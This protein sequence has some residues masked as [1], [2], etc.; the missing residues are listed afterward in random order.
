MNEVCFHLPD[1]RVLERATFGVVFVPSFAPRGLAA[2]ER[3]HA[4]ALEMENKVRMLETD[5]MK[6]QLVHSLL[7]NVSTQATLLMGFALATFGADLLPQ[8]MND[9]SSFCIFKSNAYMFVGFS[10]LL[11]N[12]CCVSF[13]MLVIVFSSLLITRS[14]EAYLH[15]GG[16][17]AVFRTQC[18]VSE[19]YTWAGLAGGSFLT[20]AILV[21][22]VF[23]GL[24]AFVEKAPGLDAREYADY[25]DYTTNSGRILYRC[26]DLEDEAQHIRR[27]NFGI[28]VASTNTAA[29]LL[30]IW[31]GIRR[32][33]HMDLMFM[34]DTCRTS[35]SV[36]KE[37]DDLQVTYRL[38]SEV[39]I[40]RYQL[41]AA[42]CDL[43][44]ITRRSRMSAMT[45]SVFSPRHS[46]AE[47]REGAADARARKAVE[48][49]HQHLLSAER[50]LAENRPTLK[51]L[52]KRVDRFEDSIEDSVMPGCSSVKAGCSPYLHSSPGSRARGSVLG[53][54][55]GASTLA[56]RWGERRQRLAAQLGGRPQ[57]LPQAATLD[58][59]GDSRVP[60]T[61]D[62]RVPP[63][64]CGPQTHS[65]VHK[66]ST[67][68]WGRHA[69]R[70]KRLSSSTAKPTVLPGA[71]ADSVRGALAL[72]SAPAQ[73]ALNSHPSSAAFD[74]PTKV[75]DLEIV[76]LAHAR[77]LEGGR[78]RRPMDDETDSTA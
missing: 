58:G 64:S 8:V 57:R 16:A 69:H 65:S 14:Q 75:Q 76:D 78:Q 55:L 56:P 31:Y 74:T 26:L 3:I 30:F 4:R 27:E 68:I 73:R 36:L 18:F 72:S 59:T 66:A 17:V 9:V 21:M 45:R 11:A 5:G 32:F 23:T 28:A 34:L 39:I 52:F 29:F 49:A 51:A 12:T 44:A 20:A 62:S 41:R 40:A 50:R 71:A 70:G 38:K 15:S 33:R 43:R 22:W 25:S 35:E 48:A 53:S 10:F 47:A 42:E 13:C 7:T 77:T 46:L 61:G 67:R 19:V 63:L 54:V 2:M 37:A 1:F 24:P 6:L 60:P